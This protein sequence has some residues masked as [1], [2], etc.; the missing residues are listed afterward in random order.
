MN[1][2]QNIVIATAVVGLIL[3]VV[4]LCPWRIESKEKIQWGPIYQPPMTYA[5]S[6]DDDHGTQG[7]SRIESE[8]AHIVVSYLVLEVLVLILAGSGLY[9][10]FSDSEDNEQ[11]PSEALE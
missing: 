3:V 1:E 7:I 2:R 10:F 8:E 4:Y 6:Y 9:I 11:T 5:R